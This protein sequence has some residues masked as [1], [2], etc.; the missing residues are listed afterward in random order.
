MIALESYRASIGQFNA[1]CMKGKIKNEGF[2]YNLDF[3][4]FFV[5]NILLPLLPLICYSYDE[6]Y[7]SKV[8][9]VEGIMSGV[10]GAQVGA[11]MA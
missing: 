7:M 3:I 6:G 4:K 2:V 1:G 5:I 8:F 11:T 9:I 10:Q